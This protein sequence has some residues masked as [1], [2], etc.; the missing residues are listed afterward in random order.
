MTFPKVNKF[1]N[2]LNKIKYIRAYYINVSF[3]FRNNKNFWEEL[4]AYFPFTTIWVSD[5]IS[6]KKTSVCVGKE[7]NKARLQ[8]WFYWCELIMKYTI[9]MAS[10]GMIYKLGLMTIGSGIRVILMAIMLVLLMRGIY[11]VR[12][13][14]GLSRMILSGVWVTIDGFWIGNW[15]YWTLTDRNCK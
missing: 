11:D 12:H 6:R 4:I 5:T 13:W 7:V 9:E 3:V 14:N 1:M 8:W 15:I 2:C 10:D